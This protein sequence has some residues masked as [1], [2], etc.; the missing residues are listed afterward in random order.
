MYKKQAAEMEKLKSVADE[1]DKIISQTREEAI[2]VI[3]SII[4]E[5]N[6]LKQELVHCTYFFFFLCLFLC[7]SSNFFSR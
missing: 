6:P 2:S 1:Y 3:G 4:G 7:Q 5:Q